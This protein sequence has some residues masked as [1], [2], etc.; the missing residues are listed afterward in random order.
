MAGNVKTR[1]FIKIPRKGT[2]MSL[3][4]RFALILAVCA[5]GLVLLCLVGQ[6]GF[7]SMSETVD[8]L[9][10]GDMADMTE[11]DYPLVIKTQAALEHFVRADRAAYQADMAVMRARL[12][13]SAED[14]AACAKDVEANVND[15]GEYTKTA[16]KNGGVSKSDFEVFELGYERWAASARHSLDLSEKFFDLRRDRAAKWNSGEKIFADVSGNMDKLDDDLKTRKAEADVV[17]RILRIEHYVSLARNSVK[18][19]FS[20]GDKHEMDLAIADFNYNVGAV[21]DNL[22]IVTDSAP[23]EMAGDMAAFK[24][25][26]NEWMDNAN[27]LL[28]FSIK[29]TG[30]IAD[31]KN[32]ETSLVS[33]FDAT[34]ASLDLLS[35]SVESRLPAMRGEID[36]KLES[37]RDRNIRVKSLMNDT[38]ATFV[39][40]SAIV[41][42]AMLALVWWTARRTVSVLRGTM[43]ELGQSSLRVCSASAVMAESGNVLAAKTSE[44]A[45]LLESTLVSLN[46]ILAATRKNAESADAASDGIHTV[47]GYTRR[48]LESMN[49]MIVTMDRINDSVGKTSDI[50]RNIEEIA[51]KTN[52]LALNAA[53]EAARAGEAGAGFAVVAEEIRQLARR[54]A[55]A[56]TESAS[57]TGDSRRYVKEGVCLAGDLKKMFGEIDG[58]VAG[59]S[60]MIE[61]VAVS[62]TN[63]KTHVE[64]IVADA[65]QLQNLNC[66]T[67]N[68]AEETAVAGADLEVQSEALGNVVGNIETFVSGQKRK[69]LDVRTA[70]S[71][72][73][74]LQSRRIRLQEV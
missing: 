8:T 62:S 45:A 44:H 39:I 12:S 65:K 13:S 36:A 43:S 70:K 1:I 27:A 4:Y 34:H 24:Q 52:I 15:V 10:T 51:F 60:S 61:D 19:M 18:S 63:E 32:A 2:A 64:R 3:A 14:L 11:R 6:R 54:S 35:K 33:L 73:R 16:V 28:T 5:A 40:L 71:A 37:A 29:T 31:Y 9:V 67:A 68:N 22:E 46:T 56:A 50:V 58:S 55:E 21:Y 38:I 26:F 7:S 47:T 49:G 53:V 17:K 42:M 66:E 59:V 74:S 20:I 23:V 57:L 48:G 30:N 25:S 72:S 69:A 41:G